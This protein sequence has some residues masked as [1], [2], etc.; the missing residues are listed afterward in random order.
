MSQQKASSQPAAGAAPTGIKAGNGKY[1]FDLATANR[2]LAGG[3]YST[4]AGSLIEGERIQCGLMNMPKGT[5][6]RPHTHPNEQWIYVVQGTLD[7]EI[8]GVKSLASAGTLIYVPANAVHT[9]VAIPNQ[10]DVI[11]FTCKDMS[12]GIVGNAVDNSV[13]GPRYAPGFEKK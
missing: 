1:Y 3:S 11:F 6:A 9:V 13:S 12:Y 2:V 7:C 4:A 10:G 5:G 8:E